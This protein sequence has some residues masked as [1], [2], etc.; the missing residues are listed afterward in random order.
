MYALSQGPNAVFYT[1]NPPSTATAIVGPTGVTSNGLVAVNAGGTQVFAGSL[2]ANTGATDLYSI[3]PTTGVATLVG[4]TGFQIV[5]GLFVTGTLYGFDLATHAI[6][7]I[8]TT[9]GAGTQVATYSLPNG[10]FINSSAV[11]A[12]RIGVPEPSSL[13]LG[14]MAVIAGGSIGLLRRPSAPTV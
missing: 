13:I 10:D 1:L 9:T 3:N 11:V 7:A 4:S 14:L 6:V 12:S 8:N 5:D 2:D